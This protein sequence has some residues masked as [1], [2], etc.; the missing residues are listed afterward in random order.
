MAS[1]G[2]IRI[3]III[4]GNQITAA[5][6]ALAAL[7]AAANNAGGQTD[8]LTQNTN[9]ASSGI[10]DMAISIG[11]VQV[12]SKAFDVLKQAL[13]GAISRFDTLVGFPVIMQQMGF[14]SEQ[15]TSSINKLSDGIQGLPTTLDGIVKN[16]QGI[17][18][19]TG[20]LD[21]ATETTLALNNAFLAS[22]SNAANAERGLTQ[23]VQMLSKGQVDMMSWRTLQETMGYAL[24]E[25][26]TAFDLA[27]P[28]DLYDALKYGNIT[29]DAFN[30]KLIEL[31]G[32]VGGFAELAKT[33]SAGIAT[34]MGNLK[35]TVVVGVAN[36]IISF[37]NLSKAV[38][39]K[40]IAENLDGLKVVIKA[41]FK[42]MGTAIESAVPIVIAF[43][44][45]IQSSI[46]IIKALTP[47]IIGLVA[48]YATFTVV[49]A[50]AAA[51]SLAQAAISGA[52]TATRT[53]T[54]VT[55]AQTTAQ[56]LLT[57]ATQ[58]EIVARLAQ[59]STISIS[60]L[61]IGTLTGKIT[62]A[63]AATVLKTAATYAWGAAMQFMM[64]PIGWITAG[65][66]LLV[67]GVILLVKWFN[68]TTEEGERLTGATDAL[69]E[70]TNALNGSVDDTSKA[71]ERNQ[72][73]IAAT[74]QANTDLIAKIEQLMAVEDRSAA[75]TKELKEYVS[76]LNG[77][78]DGLGLSYDK[79]A[80]SL[81]LS[82]EQIAARISLMKEQEMLIAGQERFLVISKEQAEVDMKLSETNAL[83]EEWNQKKEEGTVKAK[84]AKKAL[85]ELDTQEQT[86][87]ETGKG[88][89]TQRVETEKQITASVEAVAKATTDSVNDQAI[90]YEFLSDE[91]KKVVDS[92][93][94]SWD[95]YLASATNMFDT[96][97][98]KSEISVGK[99]TKNLEHNQKVIG[100]WSA[101]IAKLAERGIDEG[102]LNTLRDAGPESAGHVKAIVNSSDT[103]LKKL[104]EAFSKGGGV[105]TKALNTSLI[106]GEKEVMDSIGHLATES[107]A[108]LAQQI[109][110][111][112]FAAIGKAMPEG[113]AKGVTEGTKDVVE[114]SK[115]MA[116]ETEKAFKGAMEIKSPSGVF[117][118]DGIHITEGVALGINDG[119]PKVVETMNKLA[120]AMLLPFANISAE[121]QKIGGFAA[122][123]LN[124]G[125]NNGASKVM[126]TAR[127]LANNVAAEMRNALDTHS[128]S[129]V[130]TEI[131]KDTGDGLAL[132]IELTKD[133]NKKA[134]NTVGGVIKEATKKNASE[135]TKIAAEAEKKRTEIQN[136]YAKKRAELSKKSASSS[137]A[138]LKTHKNK[139]GEI[140]T[141]GEAKVYKIRQD[142]SAKLT[143]LNEDEQKKLATVNTKAYADM[144][145]KESELSKA[146]L[147]ALKSFV[148]DKKSTEDMSLAAESEVWRKSLV[149]FTDGSKERIEVQKQHQA[150]LNT[151][152]DKILKE[153][154]T[155]IGKVATI[156]DKLAANEQK[157]TDDYTK[158][159]D[160]RTKA[161]TNFVGIFDAYEY[162]FEQ[163]GQDLT[164]NLRSQVSALEEWSRMF[165]MLSGKA[166]DK[167][168]LEELR[169]MGVKALPQMVALNTMTDRELTEYSNLY[170]QRSKSARE[171]AEKEMAPMKANTEKQIIELRKAAN[172]ELTLLEVDWL[173][174]MKAIT[175]SSDEELKTLKSIGVSAGQGLLNGLSSMESSL[176]NKA[177]S[178]AENVKKAMAKALDINSPSRWM[179]D[180][181]AGN[182]ALGFIAGVDKNKSKVVNAASRFGDLMKPELNN[183]TIPNVDIRPFN[184]TF[185][186]GY[187]GFSNKRDSQS[188]SSD[189][190]DQSIT[191]S[192]MQATINIGG[193]EAKGLINFISQE[194]SG[195][196][197]RNSRQLKGGRP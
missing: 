67:T 50:A 77:A 161:L 35:N 101:N 82:S 154:E 57:G 136:D 49:T 132:G 125:L 73:N 144:Q 48:A 36:M 193:Y 133:T 195:M 17:A 196:K 116:T 168:L 64:G 32:G 41:A 170:K 135:V 140:V 99:M 53:L 34:S 29:F 173:A 114:A 65:I 22:G 83:Q 165:E 87:I 72:G 120:K 21:G 93:K 187:G 39:G 26:A 95:D 3:D 192:D 20:D 25:T 148:A 177:R 131:G 79:E 194:Q 124:I 44:S 164:S 92:L 146:R 172:K 5:S 60:T 11:L 167:G 197:Y 88:L 143:K 139:K 80:N 69:T 109:Q 40:S 45:V 152:N 185:G 81:S 76:S 71:F 121:F 47:V 85:E 138:A 59:T 191:M 127:N 129:K 105:A 107:G 12:A 18:I 30:T 160:D 189:N 162:K 70:S 141:T 86:L 159:V 163:S 74:A 94:S 142:S 130:T 186:G 171:Q 153:N 117:K 110:M 23:Y 75:Q 180:F 38:T 178:I 181:I 103:E 7:A 188:S 122:D 16:A 108:T 10:R 183:I 42:V 1:D 118:R 115:K 62:L 182:M 19:L 6:A 56:M 14:S 126:A 111:A 104:S 112:D 98:T 66:G 2:S 169:I 100:E 27:S 137:Q 52:Q 90:A 63:T 8:S 150:A 102:L 184:P 166:I 128:P 68:K 97:S 46:P 43:S 31:N 151:L 54:I 176:V 157:L 91:Q 51:I 106:K 15:A 190:V 174:K 24:K 55:A 4:D 78:V 149:L 145:K 175:R 58:A 61:V 9:R 158:S 156:N 147:E 123:G 119:T 28:N 155:F 134:V 37:D 96:L 13:G 89:A 84:E 33:S 179:R 113:T